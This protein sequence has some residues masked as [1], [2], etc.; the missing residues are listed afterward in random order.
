MKKIIIAT[1][2]LIFAVSPLFSQKKKTNKAKPPK[3]QAEVVQKQDNTLDSLLSLYFQKNKLNKFDEIKTIEIEGEMEIMNNVYAYRLQFK[4]PHFFRV[5]ERFQSQWIY[6]ILNGKEMKAITKNGL[7][8]ITQQEI[9]VTYN[10]ISYMRGFLTD[11][12]MNGFQITYLGLDT[13]SYIP[14]KSADPARPIIQIP[15]SKIPKGLHHII[16]ISTPM[17]ETNKVYINKDNLNITLSTENPF[18]FA[19]IGPVKFD[20]YEE[21]DGY[22]FPRRIEI[23]SQVFPAIFRI[24]QI[25]LNKEFP[26]SYFQ[27]DSPENKW[28]EDE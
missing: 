2:L 25:T 6:R 23:I 5:K 18:M 27:L 19:K 10:L 24:Q 14:E 12:A 8:D 1:F 21:T 9:D 22:I 16:Q 3:T 28:V 26:D 7:V 17:N 15:I 20:L 11:Y 13:I 4:P